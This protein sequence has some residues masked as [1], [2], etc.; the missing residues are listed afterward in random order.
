MTNNANMETIIMTTMMTI[1]MSKTET[2]LVIKDKKMDK[3]CP[4]ANP[5]QTLV[6]VPPYLNQFYLRLATRFKIIQISSVP[7]QFRLMPFTAI[8]GKWWHNNKYLANSRN[9]DKRLNQQA[10]D[11]KHFPSAMISIDSNSS[12]LVKIDRV[13]MQNESGIWYIP[14]TS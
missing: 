10:S 13:S 5:F 14:R 7:F 3:C 12:R 2:V 9:K 4:A 6:L 1:M 8:A 11:R